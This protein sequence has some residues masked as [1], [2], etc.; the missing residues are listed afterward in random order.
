MTAPEY[1]VTEERSIDLFLIDNCELE[2]ERL[3]TCDADS[4]V[5]SPSTSVTS[6]QRAF[7]MSIYLSEMSFVNT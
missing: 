5:K 6:G 1:A 3:E 7:A 4:S 2:S